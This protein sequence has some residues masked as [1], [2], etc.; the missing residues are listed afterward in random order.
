MKEALFR[1]IVGPV[2]PRTRD[3]VTPAPYRTVQQPPAP[4]SEAEVPPITVAVS[5][6]SLSLG[7]TNGIPE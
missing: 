5:N 4:V 7:A 6:P 3:D 2:V 1:A